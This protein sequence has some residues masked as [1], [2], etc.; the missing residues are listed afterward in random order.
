[1]AFASLVDHKDVKENQSFVEYQ[2][3][4]N[5]ILTDSCD[6]GDNYKQL[7]DA[8]N[9]LLDQKIEL[10]VSTNEYYFYTL[11]SKIGYKD[12]IILGEFHKDLMPFFIIAKEK[13]T[14]LI[15]KE[16]M[17]LP[18]I[19]SQFI[20]G[21]LKSWD[22]KKEIIIK[23]S[24]LHEMLDTP[25]SL[26]KDFHN[27]KSRVLDKAYKDINEKTELNFEFEPIKTG[28][29]V[30]EIKF[31]FVKNPKL[32][33]SPS[34]AAVTFLQ[35]ALG[36]QPPTTNYRDFEEFLRKFQNY[37]KNRLKAWKLWTE[38]HEKGIAPLAKDVQDKNT[39]SIIYFL[40]KWKNNYF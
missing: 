15:L 24:D 18:S 9:S 13:F 38:L 8:A 25:Q 23:L 16:Y 17:E 32:A 26:K 21:F 37:G 5:S 19:Y 7:K 14:K 11:F 33:T 28:R 34:P 40:D 29:A 10:K 3:P 2:I 30:S 20:Y 22:D 4:A 1:M 12:G 36:V 35:D 6:G 27:F 39:L 31:M